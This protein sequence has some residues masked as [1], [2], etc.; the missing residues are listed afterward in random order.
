M[1]NWEGEKFPAQSGRKIFAAAPRTI[2][3]C[4]P[5][6]GIHALYCPPV[7]DMHAVTIMSLKAIGLQL[8][9]RHCVDQQAHSL[10]F[11]EFQ[12]DHWVKP[13]KS[14]RAKTYSCPLA[15][16]GHSPS[17]STACSTPGCNVRGAG[18]IRTQW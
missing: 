10:F 8:S 18:R 11:T 12:S 14:G 9:V 15:S 16:K 6:I 4:P 2:P 17:L 7:E 13:L 1:R 5:L 3:V